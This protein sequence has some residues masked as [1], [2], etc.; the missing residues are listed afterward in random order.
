[1]KAATILAGIF[2]STQAF[3]IS[4]AHYAEE[5]KE[6]I[7]PVLN[8]YNYGSFKGQENVSINYATYRTNPNATR[9]LV[10]LPG[11]TEQIEKYAEV[12]HTLDNGK[13]A[14]ELQ[15]FLM[16]HRGQ[17]SSGRMINKV[18]LDSEKGYVDSFDNYAL[19]VKTFMDKVVAKANCSE[20]ILLAHSM[21][22]GI[23]VDFMQKYPEY[24]DR[25]A[26]SSPMIDIQTAPFK[27]SV[28]RALVSLS[29]ALGKEKEYGPKQTSFD[30][31]MPFSANTFTSS[32]ERYEMAMNTFKNY[33]K[34][35]LGG[36]TNGWA[37][38]IMKGT[39]KI[40]QKSGS[41][42]I[43]L[44]IFYAGIESFT[45]PEASIRFCKDSSDCKTT[46]LPTSKHE[47]L[48]D[49]DVNRNVVISEL[50]DFFKN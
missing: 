36:V 35:R 19:D 25:A 24:F 46:F 1:M 6:K 33:P 11:R 7:L 42:R 37:N 10:I 31:T 40:R 41:I 38:Q 21:G 3:A 16:D 50:E 22:G 30:E 13:L 43:P 47:V 17:G 26:L 14:G 12:V 8:H 28:A 20:K 5:Y 18:A 49:R 29:V 34:T 15:F 39:K 4:E 9:C 48:M 45:V 44:H 2:L 32:P 23:A 27:Y